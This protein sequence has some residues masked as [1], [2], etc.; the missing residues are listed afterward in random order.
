M[1]GGVIGIFGGSFSPPHLGHA[2][3]LAAFIEQEKP[4]LTYVIPTL[5]PPH[6]ALGG[7]AT[8]EE[9]LEMCRLA[10]SHLPVTVSDR[11]IRRGG[12]S[13]TV[14]TLEELKS[15][16]NRLVFL[17]GTDMLLTLEE[18]HLPARIFEL[19]EIVYV[20][21]EAGEEGQKMAAR[22]HERAEY[23]RKKYGAVLRPLLSADVLEISST[24]IRD[25]LAEGRDTAA[26]LATPVKEYI[27]KCHLYGR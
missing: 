27:D 19:A 23:Y 3:A 9:R 10:F 25:A 7:D 22:L 15:A 5:V 6:K 16:D 12:K 4:E 1:S 8:A 21:R 20:C 24:E 2:R 13:Y 17:C 26:Y 18:W 14:L 11:E